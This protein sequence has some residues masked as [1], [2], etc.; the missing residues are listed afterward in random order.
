MSHNTL[1]PLDLPDLTIR[2][3]LRK[4]DASFLRLTLRRRGLGMKGVDMA[5]G[6]L[7]PSTRLHG[8]NGGKPT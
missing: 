2:E 3:A 4:F 6:Q 7:S 5:A 8:E 1:I